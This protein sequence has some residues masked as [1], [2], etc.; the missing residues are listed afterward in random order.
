MK[1]LLFIPLLCCC[2][3]LKSQNVGIGTT[4]PDPSAALDIQ[5][6]D[7]G[8][9]IP[10]IDT[11]DVTNPTVG[12]MVFQN[13]DQLFYFYSGTRW[14]LLGEVPAVGDEDNDTK[15]HLEKN[16]D[17]D[18]IRFD[19]AGN[20][21][22][23]L[24]EKSLIVEFPGYSTFIGRFAGANDD[25]TNNNNFFFGRSAGSGNTSGQSNVFM[26]NFSGLFNTTGSDISI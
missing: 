22:M 8:I 19:I 9:L 7:K 20:E 15:I 25:G 12:L 3:F 17:E 13:T 10:R 6:V 4:T 24:D 1:Y 11:A 16:P 2:F 26:G 5:S 14:S 18:K 21:R 23:V